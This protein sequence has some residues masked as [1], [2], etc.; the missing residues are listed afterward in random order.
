MSQ[1][2]VG[3]VVVPLIVMLAIHAIRRH[4]TREPD[5]GDET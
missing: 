2:G 1:T 4:H 5:E 3:T